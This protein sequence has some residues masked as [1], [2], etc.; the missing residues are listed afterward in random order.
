MNAETAVWRIVGTSVV[1]S[2]HITEQGPCQDSHL[3]EI[4]SSDTWVAAIGDGAG[5]A[6]SAKEGSQLAVTA[7]VSFLAQVVS[8]HGIHDETC[9]NEVLKCC[10]QHCHATMHQQATRSGQTGGASLSDYATTL[11]VILVTPSWIAATQV[12]DGAVVFRSI[13]G[14]LALA[15]PPCR[16]EYVNESDFITSFDYLERAR[17][18]IEDA[19][20][21][22]AVAMLSDGVE[23]LS[24][25]QVRG[26]PHQP[27][28]GPMF[29]FA[30]GAECKDTILEE[31]L[32]SKRV[33][34][35]TDDDK[36][37]L[38]A[39]KR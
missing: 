30:S 38:L 14:E 7:A 34:E 5:S 19:R 35:R 18:R 28:F 16:G 4:L 1:G 29:R 31:F 25:D 6:K 36:T 9:A 3:F 17:F 20:N 39:V 11:L 24:I 22:D 12:G 15:I 2:S 10:L 23:T 21:I 26:I 33:C 13:S 8:E 37:L 27:F 32:G